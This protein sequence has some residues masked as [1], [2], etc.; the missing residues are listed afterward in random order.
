[1]FALNIYFVVLKDNLF[2]R[3]HEREKKCFNLFLDF[4]ENVW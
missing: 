4:R 2:S 3:A 1:M